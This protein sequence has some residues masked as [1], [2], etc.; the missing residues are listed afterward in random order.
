MRWIIWTT[1]THT[2]DLRDFVA[3]YANR[4]HAIAALKGLRRR[5][6]LASSE[7]NYVLRKA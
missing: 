3:E 1:A 7:V 4:G 2:G 5:A 6:W